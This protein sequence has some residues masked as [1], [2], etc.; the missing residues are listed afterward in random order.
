MK[1]RFTWIGI[2]ATLLVTVSTIFVACNKDDPS[3]NVRYTGRVV[4]LNTTTPFP[5]CLVQVTDGSNIHCQAY[6]DADGS[7]SLT[8]R[9]GEINGNYYLLAGDETCVPKKVSLGGYGRAEVDLGVIEV[10]GP[11]IPVVVTEEVSS[12]SGTCAIA[13][14]EVIS[15]GRLSLSA[16]GVCYGT[17][18]YPT[19]NDTYTF[20]GTTTGQFT[21]KLENLETKTI[22][23]L[24][25]YATN[26]LGTAYGDQMV[27]VTTEGYPVVQTN[28]AADITFNSALIS[29]EI[30]DDGG[31]PLE[32]YGICWSDNVTPTITDSYH[33]CKNQVDFAHKIENLERNTA[34]Y[35]RAYARNSAG[36]SYGNEVSFITINGLPTISTNS[37][38]NIHST[39]ATC[40]GQVL[41]DGG[42]PITARGVCWSSIFAAPT[43]ENNHTV[44]GKGLGTFISQLTGLSPETEYYVRAYAT[45][46]A[47][48]VYGEQVRFVTIDGLP[49]VKTSRVTNIQGASATCGGTITS[50]G[51][52]SITAR[53]VCWSAVTASPTIDDSHTTD[54]VG[55]GTFV[56]HL[57][58]LNE[59]TSY[60]VRAYATNSSGTS[61][62]EQVYFTTSIDEKA[63]AVTTLP[64]TNI[65]SSCATLNGNITE[66][67][68]PAY[69]ERGFC[70]NTSGSPTIYD[71]KLKINGAGKGAY[72]ANITFQTSGTE[73]Y[74]VRAYIIQNNQVIYGNQVTFGPEV[75]GPSIFIGNVENVGPSYATMNASISNAG[76]P[77]Y[78]KRGFCY[79]QYTDPKIEYGNCQYTEES[80]SRAEVYS[81]TLTNLHPNTTYYVAAYVE[82]LGHRVY[83]SVRSFQ[84]QQEVTVLMESD[85]LNAQCVVN[86]S[87]I[88]WSGTL[89]GG[90]YTSI[91]YVSLGFV[92]DKN[93]NPTVG[94]G[95]ATQVAYNN[96]QTNNGI[97]GF[98]SNVS[99]WEN[100]TTYYVRAYVQMS[101]GYVYSDQIT[102][103][104]S[105]I[106]PNIQTY[107]VAELQAQNEG[108]SSEYWQAQFQGI[109]YS[110]GTPPMQDWGFVYGTNSNPQVNDGLSIQVSRQKH[111]AVP[112]TSYYAFATMVTGLQPNKIYY[113]RTFAR[114]AAGYTYGGVLSFSTY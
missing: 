89:L 50:D 100:A 86:N 24:R 45:N 74:Y 69:T 33:S 73:D 66:V 99:G 114:T 54:G 71:V 109:A 46:S 81:T 19:I 60:Y 38:I 103:Q 5:E 62:G 14:G 95:T 77:V 3:E 36:L 97:L 111:V 43:I 32:D 57:T 35:A 4:Y 55:N 44:D 112:N 1:T 91:S 87:T 63:A 76:E 108:T 21:T 58:N 59:A 105:P 67:G 88:T 39:Y 84:T 18:P 20:E 11:S 83:S 42:Y 72:A 68:Y 6:T 53:G 113:V 92:Y 13:R 47:G 70:Y 101:Y 110:G 16:R 49:Q 37:I 64:V 15:D 17:K 94:N 41:S 28:P 12:M 78:S 65:T 30:I 102:I 29:G 80:A 25:A 22:Y 31:S 52:S 98:Y 7:F 34:Y 61:Y 9:V 23:Y 56:S 93:P 104:M 82:W 107:A 2:I 96:T 26:R 40:G 51:G 10:E 90:T 8:V 48:T 79:G 85:L 75:V 106:A 27:F